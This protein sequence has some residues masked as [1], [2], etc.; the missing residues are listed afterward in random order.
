MSWA[1]TF[2]H[3]PLTASPR[4]TSGPAGSIQGKC[5]IQLSTFCL[6]CRVIAAPFLC[7]DTYNLPHVTIAYS[8]QHGNMLY[9]LIA[10]EQQAVPCTLGVQAAMPSRF[11]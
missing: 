8:I 11:L 9:W 4:A 3:H 7:L 5:P 2:T 1:F 10:W 6:L